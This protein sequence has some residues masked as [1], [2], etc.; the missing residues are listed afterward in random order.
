MVVLFIGSYHRIIFCR[1]NIERFCNDLSRAEPY[2][3]LTVPVK[4]GY[5]P[6]LDQTVTGRSYPGRVEHR[7]LHDLTRQGPGEP[8][9]V[10]LDDVRRW[11]E[12][13]IA[14]INAGAVKDVS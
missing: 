3:D 7:K 5:F 13:I 8:Q 2:S 6:K 1:Y 11:G 4:E 9:P 14:A 12:A 10:D